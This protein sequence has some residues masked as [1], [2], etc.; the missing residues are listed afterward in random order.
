MN[1]GVA[2]VEVSGKVGVHRF[3]YVEFNVALIM[4]VDFL[5]IVTLT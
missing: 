2:A 4:L 5:I 1:S 3:L